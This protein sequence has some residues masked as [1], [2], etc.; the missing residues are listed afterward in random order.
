MALFMQ[1]SGYNVHLHQQGEIE[2]GDADGELMVGTTV[3]KV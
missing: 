1:S 3:W 2:G